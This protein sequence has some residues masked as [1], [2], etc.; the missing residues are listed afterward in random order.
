M[1]GE[2]LDKE[3]R[4]SDIVSR[5]GGE[6]FCIV[7]TNTEIKFAVEVMQRIC[8][9][10]EAMIIE[11]QNISFRMTLSV[12]LSDNMGSSFDQMISFADEKLYKAKNE[13]RN[14]VVF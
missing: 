10:V 3:F 6:E 1:L 5:Y 4:D 14:R 11:M 7:L 13:G 8:S 9:K 12:G 2:L